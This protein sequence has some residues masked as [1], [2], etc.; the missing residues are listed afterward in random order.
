MASNIGTNAQFTTSNMKP[1]SGEQLDALWGQNIADN[2]GHLLY[3]PYFVPA[4]CMHFSGTN[5]SSSRP[6]SYGTTWFFKTPGH[7]TLY[8][9][10]SVRGTALSGG[11][12]NAIV[13]LFV[14][15]TAIKGTTGNLGSGDTIYEYGSIIR[16]ISHLGDN[17]FHRLVSTVTIQ[18]YFNTLDLDWTAWTSF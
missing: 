8:G 14:D 11:P 6:V 12:G 17:Q 16:D 2:T 4:P 7:N 10:W 3:R 5:N 9:S 1:A 13:G 18:A 15:G